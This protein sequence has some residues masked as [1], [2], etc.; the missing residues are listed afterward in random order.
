MGRFLRNYCHVL[1]LLYLAISYFLGWYTMTELSW[2]WAESVGN[3]NN[4]DKA[5]ALLLS[6]FMLPIAIVLM[7]FRIFTGKPA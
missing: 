6:P 1:F 2:F 7:I 5:A 4:N 3:L